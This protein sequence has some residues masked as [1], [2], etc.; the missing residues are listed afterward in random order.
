MKH[1]SVSSLSAI[2]LSIAIAGF[3]VA[4][5]VTNSPASNAGK[6][7]APASANNMKNPVAK[8]PVSIQDGR[9]IFNKECS[10]CH[11]PKGLGNGPKA[12]DLNIQP[13]N[14]AS[15]L[16]QSQSDG[17]IFWKITT[18]NKPMPTFRTAYSD[19]DR[20]NLVNFVRT[21]GK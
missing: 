6:W 7:M 14:L 8:T 15:H 21:L 11:G 1:K 5:I 17:A 2:F 13:S 19:Q 16:V 12:G 9:K 3:I 10:S 20:W 4:F 18:G